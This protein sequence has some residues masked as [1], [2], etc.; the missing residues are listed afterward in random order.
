MIGTATTIIAA[1]IFAVAS[2]TSLPSPREHY[3]R[4][5]N[6]TV[7]EHIIAVVED[8]NY[9]RREHYRRRESITAAERASA[10]PHW[11]PVQE[12]H[13]YRRRMRAFVPA[14]K[15]QFYRR[16]KNIFIIDANHDTA[17]YRHKE[18]LLPEQDPHG[19]NRERSRRSNG[20]TIGRK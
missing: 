1:G 11:V 20:K 14:Q 8:I 19:G 15:A 18:R 7:A 5:E 10:P 17:I 13:R 16:R 4:R 2:R 12:E 9:R 3:C 6:I